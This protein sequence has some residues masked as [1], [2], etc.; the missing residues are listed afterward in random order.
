MPSFAT[1]VFV[2]GLRVSAQ[3]GINSHEKGRRQDLVVDVELEVEGETWRSI[4]RTVNYERILAHARAVAEEGHIDLVETFAWKLATA[5][6]AEP[7]AVRVR[8]RVE[9]PE[10]LAPHASA[11]IQITATRD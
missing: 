7:G 2:E 8:V 10:A 4:R 1:Q 3:I 11:G 9:K 5:C 6:L